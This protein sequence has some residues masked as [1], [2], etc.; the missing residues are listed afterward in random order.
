MQINT[1]E[2]MERILKVDLWN[3]FVFPFWGWIL[4][5]SFLLYKLVALSFLPINYAVGKKIKNWVGCAYFYWHMQEK[6]VFSEDCRYGF[7]PLIKKFVT[8]MISKVDLHASLPFIMNYDIL[9]N[10]FKLWYG[11]RKKL[12]LL[13]VSTS[14]AAVS[15]D[16][17]WR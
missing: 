12:C 2:I 14:C 17:E 15:W 8:L 9:I 3:S 6:K 13:S 10:Y 11:K 5:I 1:Q 16:W 7:W 4:C